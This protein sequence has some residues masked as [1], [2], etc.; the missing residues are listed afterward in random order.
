M[1]AEK[2]QIP[3]NSL[4]ECSQTIFSLVAPFCCGERGAALPADYRDK[5]LAGF[6]ELE[7]MAF[8]RQIGMVILK[9]A[10]Y[11]LA[12]FV[13]EA[14]LTSNWPGRSGWMG[15]PLQLEMFGDHVAGEGFFERLSQLR[16]GGEANLHL[17]EL[18]YICLQLGFEG[19]YK[20]RGLEQLMALQVDLRSQI[21]GYRGVV[22]PRLAPDGAPREGLLTRVRREVPYWVITVATVAVIFF[23][24]LGYAY[25]IDR[26]S[27][28]GLLAI[29]NDLELLRQ[30]SDDRRPMAVAGTEVAQ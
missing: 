23:G 12:A 27:R 22:D 21:E 15:R 10:K 26:L 4:L 28:A 3:V 1:D 11:A 14:V 7:R 5:I 29:Q 18:Y 2:N 16:Q 25:T 30:L 9:D 17:L 20:V 8:E 6:D 13:D 19:I 24:Y